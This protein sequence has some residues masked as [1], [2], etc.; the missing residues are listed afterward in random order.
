MN[1]V[2]S[3]QPPMKLPSGPVGSVDSVSGV[4][5]G[6]VIAEGLAVQRVIS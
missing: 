6:D 2:A 3:T 5:A 4:S 1:A